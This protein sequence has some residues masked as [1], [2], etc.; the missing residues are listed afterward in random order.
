M[1]GLSI[2]RSMHERI[3]YRK[4][5]QERVKYRKKSRHDMANIENQGM[6]GLNIGSQ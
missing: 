4:S 5:R 1:K 3:K 2:K 6:K